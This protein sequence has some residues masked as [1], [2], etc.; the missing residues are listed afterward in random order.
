M[1][2]DD[3]F[4]TLHPSPEKM[5]QFSRKHDR[6]PVEI[7]PPLFHGPE[8]CGLQVTSKTLCFRV[9]WP[10]GV[11]STLNGSREI[12]EARRISR[13]KKMSLA[14]FDYACIVCRNS[15]SAEQLIKETQLSCVCFCRSSQIPTI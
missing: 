15:A 11:F 1:H 7:P 2:I 8:F 13:W 9:N 6:Q 14:L 10:S 4:K 3:I 12:A 5:K